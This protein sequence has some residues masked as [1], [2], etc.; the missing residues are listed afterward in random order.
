MLAASCHL[1][2]LAL[3][4]VPHDGDVGEKLLADGLLYSTTV[5]HDLQ[6]CANNVLLD[7]ICEC[8]FFLAPPVAGRERC[9]RARARDVVAAS[10][11]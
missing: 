8:F 5:C 2:L 9:H 4:A 10:S 1:V 6:C 11:G 3:D 7:A